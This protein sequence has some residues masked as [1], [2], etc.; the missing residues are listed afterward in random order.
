MPAV[1]CPCGAVGVLPHSAPCLVPS[2][3]SL[4]YSPPPFLSVL[5]E[6]TGLDVPVEVRTSTPFGSP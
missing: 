2:V 4:P 1:V 5:Q 6:V 3:L